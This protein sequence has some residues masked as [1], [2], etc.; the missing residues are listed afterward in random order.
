MVRLKYICK[1]QD[2]FV[3]NIGLDKEE[4]KMIAD[5]LRVE[6]STTPDASVASLTE[7][8]DVNVEKGS[9]EIVLK[10][11]GRAINKTVTI[12][13]LIGVK[14]SFKMRHQPC[15]VTSGTKFDARRT[16]H[17]IA[18]LLVM[19]A[20]VT[21]TSAQTDTLL[22]GLP[23]QDLHSQLKELIRTAEFQSSN[24]LLRYAKLCYSSA[25]YSK[26]QRDNQLQNSFACIDAAS[27]DG[28]ELFELFNGFQKI[29]AL[30]QDPL[31]SDLVTPNFSMYVEK[32]TKKETETT[33]DTIEG[34]L[35]LVK[36]KL[37]KMLLTCAR[38]FRH[39]SAT[40]HGGKILEEAAKNGKE[41]I[42]DP[43]Q[44]DI[45]GSEVGGPNTTI[46]KEHRDLL[47]ELFEK[48]NMTVEKAESISSIKTEKRTNKPIPLLKKIPNERM[49]HHSSKRSTSASV[50][51][52]DSASADKKLHMTHP[53]YAPQN[54]TKRKVSLP[55]YNGGTD[56]N[57]KRDCWIRSDAE[58]STNMVLRIL[59]SIL[60][61]KIAT[62]STCALVIVAH[63]ESTVTSYPH[64]IIA[65]RNICFGFIIM[66]RLNAFLHDAL[67]IEE[68]NPAEVHC[69][70]AD[71]LCLGMSKLQKTRQQ[72]WLSMDS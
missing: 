67:P 61:Y 60:N 22:N 49:I 11:M 56:T 28:E 51:A 17:P 43:L 71:V 8:P 32:M 45:F 27:A 48:T 53:K 55:R 46:V 23:H 37:E 70:M 3:L 16:R 34:K 15:S 25:P 12:V 7:L 47:T 5:L 69:E 57:W 33:E 62:I 52:I 14:K 9:S 29:E 2:V 65:I 58:S 4:H 50:G 36:E 13:E 59:D 31:M 72:V 39:A 40:T 41:E 24:N 1:G 21:R 54:H 66:V 44:Q 35:K 30:E 68:M 63:F 38:N 20:G 6:T 10:A 64:Y 26:A 19:L 18:Y 42:V